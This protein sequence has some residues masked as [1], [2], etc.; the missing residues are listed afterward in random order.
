MSDDVD[1]I[2]SELWGETPAPDNPFLAEQCLCAGFDVYGDLLGKASFIEYLFLLFKREQPT[3]AQRQLLNDLAVA[4][5]NPGP[6]DYS[7]QAAMS[8]G[9]AGS[10]L[11][12]C[13]M[14]AIGVGAGNFGG[15][16]EVARLMLHW[17]DFGCAWDTWQRHLQ[18]ERERIAAIKDGDIPLPSGEETDIWLPMEHVAGFDPRTQTGATPVRQTLAH[19]A[20]VSPGEHLPWL[21]HHYS[22]LEQ[23]AG[24]GLAMTFVATAALADLDFDAEAGE[25]LF[26]LLRLP[27]AAAHSLEQR[28][29]GWRDFPFYNGKI[30]V[31]NDPEADNTQR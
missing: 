16:R 21:L 9:A 10:T 1:V 15:S 18:S 6:R 26:L 24:A 7:V 19:L 12:S 14:A 4:L 11:A 2:H 17:S 31:T 30:T 25:F 13:L 27:G 22:A 20:D 29:R 23:E 3:Q 28:I 5:A 8:G